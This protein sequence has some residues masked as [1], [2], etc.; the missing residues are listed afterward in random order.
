MAAPESLS[1]LVPAL[2]PLPSFDT[3]QTS[4]DNIESAL[5]SGRGY[6][7][8][9]R[10]YVLSFATRLLSKLEMEHADQTTLIDAASALVLRL[11]S[12]SLGPSVLDTFANALVPWADFRMDRIT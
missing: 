10:D 4:L 8:W 9:D 1:T 5:N 11:N 6:D 7:S 2:R 12:N 3:L